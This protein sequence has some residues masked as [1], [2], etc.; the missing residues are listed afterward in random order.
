M[1]PE[2]L[3]HVFASAGERFVYRQ[4]FRAE[5]AD[6]Q[7]LDPPLRMVPN[8]QFGVGV[9]SYFMI[10]DEILLI[11]RPVDSRGIPARDGY[12]VRIA[13]SGSL[14]QITPSEEMLGGGTS[15]RLYLTGDEEE[16][17]SVLQTM[18]RL[19]LDRGVPGSWPANTTSRQRSGIPGNCATPMNQPSP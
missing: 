5:Q 13:S 16:N 4:D 17:V 2:L 10:A 18:R 14:F 11:T 3:K 6:W 8:S 19:A 12:T 7:T 9:F 1:S 15:V